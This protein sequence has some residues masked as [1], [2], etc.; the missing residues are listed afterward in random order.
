MTETEWQKEVRLHS[1]KLV[2]HISGYEK[3]KFLNYNRLSVFI[4][5]TL[6]IVL[7]SLYKTRHHRR[8]FQPEN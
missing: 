4:T 1:G 5:V 6:W 7:Y 2:Q 3:N 8:S